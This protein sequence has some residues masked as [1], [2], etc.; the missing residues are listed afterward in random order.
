[1]KNGTVKAT[2]GKFVLRDI[3]YDITDVSLF[4]EKEDLELVLF[5]EV[6]AVT[7]YDNVEYEMRKVRLYHNNG[8]HTNVSA[9]ADLK[10]K[11]FVWNSAHNEHGEEAGFLCVQEHE[12][13]TKGTIEILDCQNNFIT[14]KWSG[15]ANVFW[16]ETY[17]ENVPFETIFQAQLPSKMCLKIDAFQS[18]KTRID[19]DTQLLLLNLDEFNQEVERISNSRQ[20]DDFNTILKFKVI[21]AGIDYLGEVIFTNGKLYH[22]TYLDKNCPKKVSF[23]DVDFNL[24]MAY[25]V[26]LFDID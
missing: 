12:S 3:V 5:P 2:E 16:D 20:W 13:V 25:E 8:F 22:E 23:Q 17:G 6:Y 10:G 1:M 26:F 9:F 14:I 11:E 19:K 21:H 4:A 24:D 15:L 18:T 7:E